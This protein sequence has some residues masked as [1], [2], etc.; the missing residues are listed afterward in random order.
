MDDKV[1][2]RE[3]VWALATDTGCAGVYSKKTL[4][5]RQ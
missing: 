1:A 3:F 2:D 4:P 5:A